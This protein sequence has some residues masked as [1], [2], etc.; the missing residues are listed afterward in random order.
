MNPI[1]N[2]TCSQKKPKTNLTQTSRKVIRRSNSRPEKSFDNKKTHNNHHDA[3]ITFI[4][5][6]KIGEFKIKTQPSDFFKQLASSMHSIP[7]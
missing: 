6:P 2:F 1:N 3:P 4:K 5:T 7:G